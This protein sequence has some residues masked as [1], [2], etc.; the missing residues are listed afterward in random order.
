MRDIRSRFGLRLHRFFDY[1][2]GFCGDRKYES[3]KVS[4]VLLEAELQQEIQ[5]YDAELPA[6]VSWLAPGKNRNKRVEKQ[7]NRNKR[8]ATK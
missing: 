4:D 7:T 6:E 5:K 2:H 1:E 8:N 3:D